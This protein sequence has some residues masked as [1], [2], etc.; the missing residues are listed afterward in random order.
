MPTR[1]PRG[2]APRVTAW[3]AR[4]EFQNAAPRRA[5]RRL[6]AA[7]DVVP[8]DRVL[9]VG[10]RHRRHDPGRGPT[11]PATATCSG[12]T[13][14]VRCSPGRRSA[15]RRR[16]WQ[17]HLRAGRRAGRAVR[18]RPFRPRDQPLRRDVLRRSGGR[19]RQPPPATAPGGRLALVVWQPVAGNDWVEVPRDGAGDRPRVPTDPGGRSRAV[20]A[21][22][23]RAHPSGPRRCRLGRCAPRRRPRR[24]RLRRR[25]RDRGAG[26]RARSA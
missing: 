22:R 23:R 19:L 17:R 21:R 18:R 13:S 5:H 14:R 7:A 9:D 15:P 12:S 24:V 20:R 3:V 25:A 11:S 16:V 26:T 4:E 2:T 10:L 6:F 8:S 1:P